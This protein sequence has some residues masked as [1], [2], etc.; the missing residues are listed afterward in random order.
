MNQNP[1]TVYTLADTAGLP[2][3]VQRARSENHRSVIMLRRWT[4]SLHQV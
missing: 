2:G 3:T 4:L 1:M